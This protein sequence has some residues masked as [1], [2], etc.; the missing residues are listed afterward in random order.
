MIC[1]L[2]LLS[3]SL[4]CC[5]LQLRLKSWIINPLLGNE[6]EILGVDARIRIQK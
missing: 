1:L 5:G 4:R 3:G 6:A 2:K